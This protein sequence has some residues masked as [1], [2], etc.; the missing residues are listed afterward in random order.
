ALA[1]NPRF[2]TNALRVEHRGE[3]VPLLEKEIAPRASAELLAELKAAG[4]P[5]SPVNDFAGVFADPQVVARQMI[6]E[7]Q[8]PRAGMLKVPAAPGMI[9]GAKPP[10]RRPPP[11]LG[12]H[13]AEVLR[14][15]LAFS[16]EKIA[17][18]KKSQV[19]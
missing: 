5:A 4:V 12:E 9:D 13:T 14:E 16:D 17:A 8:H 2:A 1:A 19:I 15:R 11:L 6:A 10:V 3:L 7:M 18:L